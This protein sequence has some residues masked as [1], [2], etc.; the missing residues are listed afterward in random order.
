MQGLRERREALL[1]LLKNN[2]KDEWEKIKARFAYDNDITVETV[3]KYF[4]VLR[5][6]GL[7]DG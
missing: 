6:A 2:N 1:E 3:N 5:E 7:L 4:K